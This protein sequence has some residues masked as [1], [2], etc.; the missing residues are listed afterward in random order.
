MIK[1]DTQGV[2]YAK[3]FKAAGVK[4][5][6]KKSG[7]LDVAVIYTETPAAIAGTFTQNKVAAAPVYV[8]KET[9]ATGSARAIVANAGCA[10]ACTGKQGMDDAYKTREIAAKELGINADDVIVGSTGVIGVTLPMDKLK[11]GIKDAVADLSETGSINAA[12]AIITTDTHCKTMTVKFDIGDAEVHMGAIA[13]GSG[14]IRPNMATMLCYITTDLNIEQS[15]LQKALS[16][17]VEKSFNMISVDGD[18]STNDT[19]VVLA[20]G[21]AGN[22]KITEENADYDIFCSNLMALC[23]ELAKEIAADGEGASK[24]LTINV[25]GAKSFA[26]AKT[27]GMAVANSPLVKT[28]FFG[29]DPNWGRVICAVGYSGADM[30][31]EKTVVK[32]GGITI[33]DCGVGAQYDSEAL[34]KVMREN[35]IVIDIELNLGDSDAT[36]WTCDLSYEY[37]KINGEYHT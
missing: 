33:F 30:V 8:S 6:I 31:P 7:N 25:K 2:T 22:K 15:L 29:E 20:N 28:A 35:D 4:A 14:M 9:V 3:G 37:V 1:K 24:F 10:N 17:C 13:K 26:D 11:K 23:V 34:V 19:V 5:G 32:F 16:T 12:N 27:V 21:L 36:V 18:M